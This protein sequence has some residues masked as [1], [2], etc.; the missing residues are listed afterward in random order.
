MPMP[1]SRRSLLQSAVAVTGVCLVPRLALA[2]EEKSEPKFQVHAWQ[3]H[4]RN[5][6][7]PPGTDFDASACMNPFVLRQEDEY[8][9][10]YAGGDKAGRR[11]IC[12]ATAP[13]SDVKEW[14]RLGPLFET[15]G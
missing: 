6:V 2:A 8:W 1:L 12:L 4:E 13:V 15:G 3:R 5:P 9:L 7:F 11:R 10:F 14:K